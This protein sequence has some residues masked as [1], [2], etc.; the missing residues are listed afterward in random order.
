M[1]RWHQIIITVFLIL[2][3]CTDIKS[4]YIKNSSKTTIEIIYD[5]RVYRSQLDT[6]LTL[7]KKTLSPDSIFFLGPGCDTS[8][9]WPTFIQIN[10][11][12][13][14]IK[15]TSRSQI[16]SMVNEKTISKCY[17]TVH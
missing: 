5:D 7:S 16:K 17:I 3:S 2:E 14:T 11:S 8:N 10:L 1:K 12:H 13:D 15:L 6:S 4:I 9:I